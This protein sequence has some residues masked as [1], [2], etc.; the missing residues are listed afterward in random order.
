MGELK[1]YL[2]SRLLWNPNLQARSIIKEYV[3]GVYGAGARFI[4]EWL[5]TEHEAA[6]R[7]VPAT[8][9]DPPTVGYLSDAVLTQG[10]QL[11]DAA[12][13]ATKGTPAAEEVSRARLELEYVQLAR[14]KA[15]TP[16]YSALAA[17][18]AGKI[19]RFGITQIREGEPVE[20]YLKRIGQS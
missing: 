6:R 18:V 12:E 19:H 7:G 9:Y 4:M 14:L 10:A 5:D 20:D 2:I 11:F 15:G 1:S 16:E 3:D 17:V 8:I 13:A